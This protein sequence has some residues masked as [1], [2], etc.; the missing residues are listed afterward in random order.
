MGAGAHTA[1][2]SADPRLAIDARCNLT[3]IDRD[4]VRNQLEQ[5]LDVRLLCV[6]GTVP[7]FER[8]ADDDCLR[9]TR[10]ATALSERYWAQFFLAALRFLRSALAVWACSRSR[11]RSTRAQVS[12]SVAVRL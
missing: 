9:G 11:L 2:G 5:S 3:T 10:D 8:V 7:P 12:R 1:I 4:E 6:E